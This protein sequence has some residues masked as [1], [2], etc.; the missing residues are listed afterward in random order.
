MLPA[1]VL[2]DLETTG[3]TPARDRIT[4]IA[5]IRYENGEEVARWQTLVNPHMPIPPFIQTLTGIGDDMVQAAPDFESVAPRLYQYLDGAVLVAHNVRFDHGFLKHEFQRIGIILRQK[6]LCSVKLSRLLY[7]QHRSHGLDAVIQ[8]HQIVVAA[9]HRAMGD[10][11]AVA[12]FIEAAGRELGEDRVA[13][14][15]AR[16]MTAPSLPPGLDPSLLDELPETAGVYLFFGADDAP[17]YIGKGVNLRSRVLAHFSGKT[18][19]MAQAVR[20]VE[21]LETVGEFSALLLESHLIKTRQPLHNS[22]QR[23]QRQLCAWRL[24]AAPDIHPQAQ[25]V[26]EDAIDPTALGDL[27]GLYRSRKHAEEALRGI[28]RNHALNP[29]LLGLESGDVRASS[30]PDAQHYLRLKLALAAQRLKDWPY[31]GKI[32]VRE[33]DATSQRTQLHVFEH[34]CYLASVDNEADLHDVL[35]Q[36][37]T[38]VFDLDIYKLL[39]QVLLPPAKTGAKPAIGGLEIVHF[40]DGYDQQKTSSS[41]Q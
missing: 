27:F 29:R 8:R 32:A 3:A 34:W 40:Q 18:T 17:L 22:L 21:W 20:R 23:R 13:L 37:S 25:L 35:A 9:R 16:L 36:R 10:V 26:R 12:A 33:Y 11:E 28:A 1:Y 30:E 5:L 15:V 41:S 31:P 7:P 2:L 19:D 6:V 4:E 14:E 24:A 38:P 39:Q